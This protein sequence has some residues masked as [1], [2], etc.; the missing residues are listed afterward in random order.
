[1]LYNVMSMTQYYYK[2]LK[3]HKEFVEGYVEANSQREAR[4]KVR[5]LGF[6]PTNI[7][8]EMPVS[9]GAKSKGAKSLSNI[10]LSLADK[11]FFTSYFFCNCFY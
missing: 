9:V 4:D 7:Y 6:L 8:E 10:S 3:D 11:I 5:S 1:M 2:A